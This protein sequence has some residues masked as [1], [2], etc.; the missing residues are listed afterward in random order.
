MLSQ[1]VPERGLS[2]HRAGLSDSAKRSP[3]TPALSRE[4]ERGAERCA[5]TGPKR[6]ENR[7]RRSAAR[8]RAATSANQVRP[9]FAL[10]PRTP[11]ARGSMP[12]IGRMLRGA[13]ENRSGAD[14][15]RS[16]V[17][18]KR[19]PADS[20]RTAAG[21]TNTAADAARTTADAARTSARDINAAAGGTRTS[22]AAARSRF[23]STRR[24]AYRA[25][26]AR[27][28]NARRLAEPVPRRWVPVFA[29]RP[30]SLRRRV[31]SLSPLRLCVSASLGLCFPRPFSPYASTTRFLKTPT[32]S[33]STSTTSPSRKYR[34]GSLAAPTPA[35]V[36]VRM[37]VPAGSVAP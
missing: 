20:I 15:N 5:A 35:G 4:R 9:L 26:V 2:R 29:L 21:A 36:P 23:A 11:R 30:S 28:T 37:T 19:R 13:V 6:P 16:G 17:V 34:G 18:E 22:A 27:S 8:R 14:E 33:T 7:R 32:P 10:A 24:L 25:K 3:L 12:N 31:S 1:L